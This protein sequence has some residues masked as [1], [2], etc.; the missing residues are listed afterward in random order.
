MDDEEEIPSL[1]LS[2]FVVTST[3]EREEERRGGGRGETSSKLKTSLCVCEQVGVHAKRGV[4][5]FTWVL[6]SFQRRVAAAVLYL[7][8]H[9]LNKEEE[10]WEGT[11]AAKPTPSPQTDK[12]IHTL[13]TE[14][15]GSLFTTTITRHPPLTFSVLTK[16]NFNWEW[17]SVLCVVCFSKKDEFNS[18]LSALW[19]A[20]KIL[21]NWLF[22]VD[23]IVLI[24][25]RLAVLIKIC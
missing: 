21:Q 23:T 20:K 2:A 13:T 19:P 12:H 14:R 11:D 22:C 9:T 10:G 8:T 18:L 15:E 17:I 1:P 5:L 6:L 24:L 7:Y 16:L 25:F 4:L 3:K